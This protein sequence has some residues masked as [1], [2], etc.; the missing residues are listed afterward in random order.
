[1]LPPEKKKNR[2]QKKRKLASHQG[3]KSPTVL[4]TQVAL[5]NADSEDKIVPKDMLESGFSH[6]VTI[7]EGNAAKR[8]GKDV[9]VTSHYRSKKKDGNF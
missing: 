5:I 2:S 6:L 9:D 8:N 1:M 7:K 4:S 3:I